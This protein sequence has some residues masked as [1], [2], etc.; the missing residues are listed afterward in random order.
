MKLNSNWETKTYKYSAF[1]LINENE[2]I[3]DG[4]G[5]EIDGDDKVVHLLTI[6]DCGNCTVKNVNFI[7]GNTEALKHIQRKEIQ[8][9]NEKCS[10][11]EIIDGG[12]VVIT[13]RSSVK[14]ENCRFLSNKSIMCGG[15]VSNQSDGI[16]SFQDCYFENN[17]A[18]HTGSAI[19][20]L[21][22]NSKI[23]VDKC[24]FNNNKSNL[25]HKFGLPHG[26]ISIFPQTEAEIKNSRFKLGSIPFDYYKTSKVTFTSNVY[27]DYSDWNEKTPTIRDTSI[28]KDNIKMLRK[29]WW[30]VSKTFG[31]VYYKVNP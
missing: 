3:F 24:E 25:W 8:Y 18:G 21:T 14:F 6:H 22:K 12:A 1:S 10:I 4:N 15:A 28:I 23:V 27:N 30:V 19:D 20:N 17:I 7:N 11:F 9:R 16:V 5:F 29:M 2:F 31:K 26:Q 13:G